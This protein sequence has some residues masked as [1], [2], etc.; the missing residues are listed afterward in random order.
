VEEYDVIH[1]RRRNALL[2]FFHGDDAGQFL[3]GDS[4]HVLRAGQLASDLR[5]RLQISCMK[6]FL[7]LFASVRRQIVRLRPLDV[8]HGSAWTVT[9]GFVSES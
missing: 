8:D 4:I 7:N 2:P 6:W 5:G 3:V 1:V 9:C